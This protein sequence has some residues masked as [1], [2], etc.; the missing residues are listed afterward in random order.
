MSWFPIHEPLLPDIIA[1]H[2]KWQG[3]RTALIDAHGRLSWREFERDTARI[4]NGL[5]QL[6][7]QLQDRVAVLMDNSLEMAL[8]LFGI[9]R[10]GCV[11][12]PLN[13]SISDACARS[14][15]RASS[16][17]DSTPRVRTGSASVS[18]S[19]RRRTRS[20]GISIPSMYATS[21]TALGRPEFRRASCTRT[22]AG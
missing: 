3:E 12:V 16:A 15:S 11:A 21:S 17:W 9:V 10:S 5:A 7:L 22:A 19:Q 20:T 18:S 4:A 1:Q 2:G 8:S 13:I 6:G 14:G